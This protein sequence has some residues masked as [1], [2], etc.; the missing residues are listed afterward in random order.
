MLLDMFMFV[1]VLAKDDANGFHCSECRSSSYLVVVEIE[2]QVR[3]VRNIVSGHRCYLG[4]FD[5][6]SEDMPEW[7]LLD[8]FP[9]F[10]VYG[11]IDSNGVKFP[12]IVV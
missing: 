8:F 1:K 12:G 2:R 5:G 3:A 4:V 11:D 10:T 9:W 7:Q 6:S